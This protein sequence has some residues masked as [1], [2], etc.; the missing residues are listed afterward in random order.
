MKKS[1]KPLIF[2]VALLVVAGIGG[3]FVFDGASLFNKT[4]TQSAAAPEHPITINETASTEISGEAKTSASSNKTANIQAQNGL[5]PRIL[6]NK[7]AKVTILEFSSLTC[8]HCAN[9]HENTLP[10]LKAD[11]IDTGKVRL[12]FNDFPLDGRAEIA[13]LLARCTDP[14]VYY[15]VLDTLFAQQ[16]VWARAEDFAAVMGR[17]GQLSGLSAQ[18]IDACFSNQALYEAIL[19]SKQQAEASYNIRST[20]SFVINGTL[21]SGNMPYEDLKSYLD[22]ALEAAN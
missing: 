2:I 18:E 12:I 1:P 16:S 11:Y 3:V 5:Q 14:D 19:S 8:P 22:A 7:D 13:S 20:P 6:G 4:D 17:Y 15:R 21:I 10:K 9:F